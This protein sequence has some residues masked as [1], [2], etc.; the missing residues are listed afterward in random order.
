[1][2]DGLET[3]AFIMHEGKVTEAIETVR[4]VLKGTSCRLLFALKAHAGADV[5]RV[6][7]GRVDGFSA[8]SLFEAQF[9]R[10]VL[11]EEGSVHITTPGFR[12]DEIERL[13]KLCD[14]VSLNS[15]PQLA[16]FKPLLSTARVGLRVNPGLSFV[17]DARYDPCRA[18]SKL[19]IPL[20]PLA[21]VSDSDPGFLSGVS[22]IHIHSNCDSTRFDPL[23]KTVRQVAKQ[24]DGLLHR[25]SWVN[26][27]GGYLFS[28]KAD[29][30]PLC[31]AVELL[32]ERYGVE[33]FIEPGSALV[34]E[35]G[36]LVSAVVDLVTHSRKKLAV[37]DTTVNHMP[38]VYE[39][40]YQPDVDGHR[41]KAKYS[42]HLVGSTCL[43]GDVFGEYTFDEPLEI[44]SRIVFQNM[45]AYT[46]VKAHMFNGVNLPTVYSET[47][48][49]ELILRKR[50]TYQDFASNRGEEVT[51]A[52]L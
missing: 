28:E 40:Q 41:G 50:F 48:I 45:G 6:M 17:K 5:L 43:A 52:S 31:E 49:G 32:I 37:L 36:Y 51:H 25:V 19:G 18:N 10:S 24:L 2:I 27:G 14:Y 42:Y 8:S 4:E 30:G 12:P 34:R 21:R 22:G 33:V 11:G 13:D 44:G 1:M 23:L 15:L 7:R 29:T 47:E 35:A 9:A 26:L 38:E 39:Y 3:P 20:R 16:R 46:M